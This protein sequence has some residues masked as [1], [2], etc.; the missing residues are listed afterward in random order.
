MTRGNIVLRQSY[1]LLQLLQSGP[2]FTGS[3]F[4][5]V[6]QSIER[7]NIETCSR[8]PLHIHLDIDS[9]QFDILFVSGLPGQIDNLIEDFT[10]VVQFIGSPEIILHID[11]DNDI[12]SHGTGYV[13]REII[14]HATVHKNLI[15]Q[16]H[17]SEYAGNSHTGAHGG[18]QH[19]VMKYNFISVYYILRDTGKRDRQFIEVDGVVITDCQ[20]RKKIGQILAFDN[21]SEHIGLQ[22]LL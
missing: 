15:T 7:G 3:L 20:F 11:T 1:F 2:L 9:G 13:G 21:T 22:I 12:S 10:E 4:A 16:A 17:R 18:S 8:I 19:S 5:P 6:H 14:F